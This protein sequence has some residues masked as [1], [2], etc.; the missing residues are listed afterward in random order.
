MPGMS[1][2]LRDFARQVF[3]DKADQKPCQDC[4]GVHA[5]VCPRLQ[6]VR[7]VINA[8]GVLVERE[9]TYWAPGVWESY[10]IIWPEDVYD[11]D[12]ASPGD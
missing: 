2:E 6:S 8:D 7:Q 1:Q 9:V 3:A 5:R 4:G 10:G 11:D 12:D